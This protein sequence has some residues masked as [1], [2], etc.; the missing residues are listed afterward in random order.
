MAELLLKE[1]VYAVVGAAMEVYNQLGPGFLEA[2]YQEAMEL[3]LADR[4]IPFEAQK[5]VTITYKKRVLRKRYV[6]D[7]VA[8]QS[9]LVELK[10]LQQLTGV[11]EAQLLNC[12]KASAL[13][14]GVIINFGSAP[15]LQWKRMVF[16]K[17]SAPF[18]GSAIVRQPGKSGK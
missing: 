4:A 1:E 5:E 17:T 2:V 8:Y 13:P 11:E 10:A 3:E 7:L 9:L 15:N 18:E 12:L 16:T 6:A 14:V